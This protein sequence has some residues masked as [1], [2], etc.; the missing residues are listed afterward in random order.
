M[1]ASR[2]KQL[3]LKE[4]SYM[5][6]EKRLDRIKIIVQSDVKRKR[7]Q[8]MEILT[9]K[10]DAALDKALYGIRDDEKRKLKLTRI[11]EERDERLPAIEKEGKRRYPHICA[12]SKSSTSRNYIGIG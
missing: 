2:L 12:D 10:Y 9:T 3:F 6:V 11:L 8:L 5:P 4:F 1:K 7:K